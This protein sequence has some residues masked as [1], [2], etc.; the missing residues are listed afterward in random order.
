MEG[1]EGAIARLSGMS[2][3]FMQLVLFT[4]ALCVTLALGDGSRTTCIILRL[5]GGLVPQAEEGGDIDY[6]DKFKLDYGSDDT[7]R[8]AGAMRGFLPSGRLSS[9]PESDPFLKWWNKHLEDGPS[10]EINGRL[11]PFYALDFGDKSELKKGE[12]PKVIVVQRKLQ[13]DKDGVL[14]PASKDV[15]VEVRDIWQPWLKCRCNFAV[16]YVVPNRVNI[17]KM[18]EAKGRFTSSLEIDEEQN[19]ADASK[20]AAWA[21]MTFKPSLKERMVGKTATTV[22]RKVDS[23]YLFAGSASKSKKAKK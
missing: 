8:N 16:R 3:Q 17:I 13:T 6:Y 2:S 5:R 4:A 15:D 7:K 11:K 20:G 21:K 12:N 18:M 14:V 23:R 22:K 19:K 9:L 1:L 10:E